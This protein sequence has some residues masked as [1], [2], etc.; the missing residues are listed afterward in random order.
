MTG[1]A[2]AQ[3][4][5]GRGDRF[6]ETERAL[7]LSTIEDLDQG[8]KSEG[9]RC[10]SPDRW[11]FL[12]LEFRRYCDRQICRREHTLN[13]VPFFFRL[14]AAPICSAYSFP[15][16]KIKCQPKLFEQ[17]HEPTMACRDFRECIGRSAD[18][19]G[20]ACVSFL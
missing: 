20:R 14:F 3:I 16:C 11:Y 19:T 15:P 2:L 12:I 9:T 4:E 17:S 5:S 8:Q 10:H 7:A 18:S 1:R 6:E 13:R